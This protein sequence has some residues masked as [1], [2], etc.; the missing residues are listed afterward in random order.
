[1]IKS[2]KVLL[3]LFVVALFYFSLSLWLYYNRGI[4]KDVSLYKPNYLL[5][6]NFSVFYFPTLLALIGYSFIFWFYC[7]SGNK[8]YGRII[9]T[10]T[11][12]LL[13]TVISV[14]L[15]TYVAFNWFGT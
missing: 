7:F 12:A 8:L 9:A 15:F 3:K 11:S 1:M 14:I 6:S 13:L 4:H 2:I 5:E 10:A